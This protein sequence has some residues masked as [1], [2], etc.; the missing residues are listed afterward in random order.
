MLKWE[1]IVQSLVT[2]EE[3]ISHS[4][5]SMLVLFIFIFADSSLLQLQNQLDL[6][7]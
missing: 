1:Q 2:T 7:V 5:M 4:L 6:Q 3:N